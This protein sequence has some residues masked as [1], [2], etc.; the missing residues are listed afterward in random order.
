MRELKEGDKSPIFNG[1]NQNGNIISS[2]SYSDKKLILFFYPKDNTPGCTKEA[3]NLRDN[4]ELLMGKGFSIVGVSADDQLKHQKFIDKY[5]LPFPLIADVDK[6]VINAFGCW[7]PKKFMGKEYD[8]IHRK[9][10]IIESG[11]ITKIFH[12]V[13]TNDHTNQILNEL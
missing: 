9:T 1:C 13:K 4:Y 3:C 11:V 6:T 7:G 5:S 12:K 10:F 8:G 2:E